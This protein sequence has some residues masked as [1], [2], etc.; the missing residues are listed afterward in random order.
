LKI[1]ITS[2]REEKGLSGRNLARITKI[3]KSRLFDIENEIEGKTLPNLKELESIAKAL[4][5]K[6][7]DLFESEYK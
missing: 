3:P 1:T 7:T 5:C 6:I 2:K 4:R